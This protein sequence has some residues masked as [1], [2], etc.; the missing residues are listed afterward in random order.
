MLCAL[1][2]V[3]Y[4]LLAAE[5][6][7][8]ATSKCTA[9]AC[10]T[11]HTE[12]ADF[13][14]ANS[15]C[16]ENG[17]YLITVRDNN[18]LEV[19]KSVLALAGK[20][21]VHEKVWIGLK[22]SKGSCVHGDEALHGF[23]WISGAPESSYSN[24]GKEPT[25]T[26]TEERCVSLSTST[27]DLK[28]SDGSCKSH[29]LY[30]CVYYFR[31]MCKPLLFAGPGEVNYTL[32]FLKVPVSQDVGLDMFP[33]ATF[34]EIT[35]AY[36]NDM[37]T[38][39]LCK[40]RGA[41]FVWEK[42]GPFCASDLRL[43]KHRNGGCDQL[44]VEDKAGVRCECKKDYYLGD[45]KVTCFLKDPCR[46]SPCKHKCTPKAT[47]FVC[48]CQ[49]GFE[50]SEDNVSCNDVDE[51]TQDICNGHICHNKQGSYECEC[52]KGFKEVQGVCEDIDECAESV[53]AHHAK[54]LNSQGS[55]SCYCSPGF[56]KYEDQCVDV[57]E[58]LSRPCEGI[59]TNTDGSYTCSCGPGSR[60]AKNG[61]SC[62]PDQKRAP[63]FEILLTAGFDQPEITTVKP[64]LNAE[65]TV[66]H[67]SVR[68]DG[69]VV[70]SWTLVYALCSIIPLL[71]LITL[72]AVIVVHRWNRSR[73]DAKKKTVTADSY[74]WVSSGY[75]NQLETQRNRIY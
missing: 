6:A 59:C 66:A 60:L 15:R 5:R 18:D 53:C 23:R 41:H 50:L 16:Y 30:V 17:G 20:L 39:A 65:T 2:V 58:C 10:F 49:E 61:I 62:L 19:L 48:T 38:R 33:H 70:G 75:T 55:F 46:N 32:P 34:A 40:E 67:Q 26:C 37:K 54:C 52:K 56:K 72:T 35:C 12:K 42:P 11:L 24:W 3:L 9:N 47:G 27:K 43:C 22:L 36:G 63:D 7:T 57:D 51:C 73:K 45:D 13:Q 69:S 68:K 29:A 8:C 14:K 74:C 1:F 4:V 28:W 31:G 71:L 25:S 64:R 21:S 44:C